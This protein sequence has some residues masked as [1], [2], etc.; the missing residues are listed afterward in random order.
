VIGSSFDRCPAWRPTRSRATR[1]QLGGRFGDRLGARLSVRACGGVENDIT[2][3]ASAA[4]FDPLTP[5]F[6][7]RPDEGG[8]GYLPTLGQP[9]WVLLKAIPE[10]RWGLKGTSSYWFDQLRLFRQPHPG[11]WDPVITEVCNELGLR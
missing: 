7:H 2:R 11:A 8:R 1:V 6:S 4:A 9:A 5:F 10:W 3:D